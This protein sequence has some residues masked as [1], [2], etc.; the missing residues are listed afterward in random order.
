MCPEYI[1]RC[2]AVST[3]YTLYT[4]LSGLDLGW[5]RLER[6]FNNDISNTHAHDNLLSLH[7]RFFLAARWVRFLAP[8]SMLLFFHSPLN[9][10]N[11]NNK[12]SHQHTHT[13]HSVFVCVHLIT[14][15]LLL[16]FSLSPFG[17]FFPLAPYTC[18]LYIL[19]L[20][21]LNAGWAPLKL[22]N[23]STQTP[24]KPIPTPIQCP[25]T[26][27]KNPPD[28]SRGCIGGWKK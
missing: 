17:L 21:P 1:S 4:C 6:I 12:A 27:E 14:F 2:D 16:F 15:L 11:N 25:K 3:R 9:N 5:L 8:K 26:H 20:T 10:N 18:I 23:L 19:T 28:S 7:L 13:C 22:G 24:E